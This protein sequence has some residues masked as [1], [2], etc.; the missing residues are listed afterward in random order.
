MAALRFFFFPQTAPIISYI[1]VYTLPNLKV[2]S[3]NNRSKCYGLH[4]N[5]V[6][7]TPSFSTVT[8]IRITNIN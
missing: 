3:V 7:S 4:L 8:A 5:H 1:D 2:Q 6:P